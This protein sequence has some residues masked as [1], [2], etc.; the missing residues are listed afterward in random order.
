MGNGQEWIGVDL[1][2]TLAEYLNFQGHENI[3][4]PVEEMKARV[5]RW[6]RAGIKVKIFTARVS[7]KDPADVAQAKF[8]IKKWL[9]D[10]GFPAFEITCIKDYYMTELYDDRAVQ[11]E[12]NTGKLLGQSTR[13]H[14]RL[15]TEQD[16]PVDITE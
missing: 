9:E 2:G 7:D 12:F 16:N 10:N 6:H 14:K 4:A 8:Y 13:K 1:D 3:G 15:V 11:V 5:L